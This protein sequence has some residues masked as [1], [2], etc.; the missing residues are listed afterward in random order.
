MTHGQASGIIEP[1]EL[2]LDEVPPD[3]APGALRGV[4]WVTSPVMAPSGLRV[5]MGVLPMMRFCNGHVFFINHLPARFG[6]RAAAVHA[7]YQYADEKTWL[8]IG[9]SVFKPRARPPPPRGQRSPKAG[10]RSHLVSG[11]ARLLGIRRRGWCCTVGYVQSL[12][13]GDPLN[14]LHSGL[15]PK[16]ACADVAAW[17]HMVSYG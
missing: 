15:R 5:A 8:E 3:V 12:T 1:L 11:G 16:G 14:P 6:L 17:S 4:F 7:T 9:A 13:V 10:R 2:L